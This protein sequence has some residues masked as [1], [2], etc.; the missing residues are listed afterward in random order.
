MRCQSCAAVDNDKVQG[1]TM[2][3]QETPSLEEMKELR[4]LGGESFQ[5]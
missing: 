5:I 1:V 2:I 4:D 3:G